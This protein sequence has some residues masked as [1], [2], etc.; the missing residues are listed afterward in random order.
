MRSR[1]TLGHQVVTALTVFAVLLGVLL[2]VASC[3]S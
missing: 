2:A 3:V 1:W